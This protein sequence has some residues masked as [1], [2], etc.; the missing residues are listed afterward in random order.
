MNVSA[1]IVTRGDV[2]LRP[3]I[4]S[5]P[6]E[7]EIVVWDNGAHQISVNNHER[8]E[9]LWYPCEDLA[10][11]GRYAA[12]EHASHDLIYLQ[13][14]DCIVSDPQAIAGAWERANVREMRDRVATLS[15]DIL[16]ASPWEGVV[17]NMPANFRHAFYQE[18]GLVGF[19]A[20]FHRDAPRRAFESYWSTSD[21]INGLPADA[22]LVDEGDFF[23]RTC[24]IVFTA[25]TPRVLVDIAYEDMPW[26]S[27][28]N[29]M[30]QQEN[31]REERGRMLKLAL[32][33]RDA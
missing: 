33:A 10:V 23:H 27:A 11:Y 16:D 15:G 14:D 13:D 26:A 4:D 30:W 22:G 28:P 17:C 19:G 24:D 5:L 6:H 31:H 21:L 7:W 9:P 32:E 25:L 12:I 29:R 1:I 8:E 20:V 2:G 3:I 18:H